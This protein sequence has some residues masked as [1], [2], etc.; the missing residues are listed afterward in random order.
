MLVVVLGVEVV[1]VVLGVDVV[2]LGAGVV[3]LGVVVVV[4]GVVTTGG[5]I[6]FGT[7][8]ATLGRSLVR[9]FISAIIVHLPFTYHNHSIQ[10]TSFEYEKRGCRITALRRFRGTVLR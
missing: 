2:T 4:V 3:V 5:L 7:V 9:A 10:N 1:V 8:V 6:I